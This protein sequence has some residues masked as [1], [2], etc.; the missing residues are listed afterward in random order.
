MLASFPRIFLFIISY[1]LFNYLTIGSLFVEANYSSLYSGG[2]RG[3]CL[4][5][6]S[7]SYKIF[8]DPQKSFICWLLTWQVPHTLSLL[9][10]VALHMAG[11]FSWHCSR[12]QRLVS[13]FACPA[14][15]LMGP[16]CAILLGYLGTRYKGVDSWASI[17]GP[18]PEACQ[19]RGLLLC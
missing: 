15:S 11:F 5:Y 19:D 4:N 6:I 12:R 18:H 8:S 9:F 17:A 10:S 14:S 16:Y 2:C 3:T 7:F 13:W 1:N